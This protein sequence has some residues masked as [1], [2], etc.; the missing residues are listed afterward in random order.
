MLQY[1]SEYEWVQAV[2]SIVW[3]KFI[4]LS[5]WP[6]L[7]SASVF[8]S[9]KKNKQ[10]CYPEEVNISCLKACIPSTGPYFQVLLLLHQGKK[11]KFWINHN[12]AVKYCCDSFTEN[13]VFEKHLCAEIQK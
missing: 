9:D 7:L 12:Q 11:E 5:E 1:P 2:A 10:I 3:M 8:Q 13:I 6:H 4:V